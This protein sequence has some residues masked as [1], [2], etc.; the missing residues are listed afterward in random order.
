VHRILLAVGNGAC[1]S[2][3][4]PT[5]RERFLRSANEIERAIRDVGAD[6]DLERLDNPNSQELLA[7]VGRGGT[8]SF[9]LIYTGHGRRPV[10][11]RQSYLCLRNGPLAVNRIVAA[12]PP[13]VG[14][15][16]LLLDACESAHVS[17][18][19][20]EVAVSVL[21]ADP[22]RI[23]TGPERTVL[24][25]EIPDA[26]RRAAKQGGS[27]LTDEQ[28]NELLQPPLAD[29]KTIYDKHRSR[30][31]KPKLRRQAAGPIT[32]LRL[33]QAADAAPPVVSPTPASATQPLRTS[34]PGGGWQY[35]FLGKVSSADIAM[36]RQEGGIPWPC[37][38]DTGQ[39][40]IEP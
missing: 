39:C 35:R 20:S 38:E 17:V 4:V 6:F 25:E 11:E 27:L 28:L 7:A 15:A 33:V 22:E 30:V 19:E 13:G 18:H 34:T 5:G 3:S 21:S 26:L 29:T 24:G 23:D 8:A 9:W 40:F 36:V 14:E 37:Q 16:S 10:Y 1:E 2:F 31:P 12:L 32:L